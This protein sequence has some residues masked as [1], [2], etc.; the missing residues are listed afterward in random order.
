M[1]YGVP[2]PYEITIHRYSRLAL[3]SLPKS[4]GEV[5]QDI[6]S[7]KVGD[8]TDDPSEKKMVSHY[9]N[10]CTRCEYNCH[11]HFQFQEPVNWRERISIGD[12]LFI[13][14][15]QFKVVP[16][17]MRKRKPIKVPEKD[18]AGE[19]EE[20]AS[21]S[22]SRRNDS[23]NGKAASESASEAYVPAISEIVASFSF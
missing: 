20:S 3:V 7:G 21:R 1:K 17:M 22:K 11:H 23:S 15:V 12:Y 14:G 18:D 2:L 9:L 10:H 16:T 6:E 19:S 5:V 4:D 8:E 13:Q